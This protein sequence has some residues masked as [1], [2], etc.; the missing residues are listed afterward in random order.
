MIAAILE[1]IFSSVTDRNQ[2]QEYA[3]KLRKSGFL[4]VVGFHIAHQM[5]TYLIDWDCVERL[6]FI[7]G[8]L[9]LKP[10]YSV[11][12]NE[13]LLRIYESD[14]RFWMEK[15]QWILNQLE[16]QSENLAAFR[17]EEQLRSEC[18][19]QS[20]V[21]ILNLI[22]PPG[23]FPCELEQIIGLWQEEVDVA[24]NRISQSQKIILGTLLKRTLALHKKDVNQ[25]VFVWNPDEWLNILPTA[26]R[27]SIS[28]SL[29]RLAERKLVIRLDSSGVPILE[30]EAL[31]RKRTASVQL[32]N[33]G[34]LVAK[35]IIS[36]QGLGVLSFHVAK[37]RK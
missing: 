12:T 23:L 36:E 3:T 15:A 10:E 5:I 35:Q 24:I 31:G 27:P 18:I 20:A 11:Y 2:V 33:L 9:L 17:T 6:T 16:G 29:K 26:N 4:S 37:K 22:Y 25:L 30:D 34:F 14:D 1:K 7:D 19:F 8:T 21:E 13:L 32:T 28:N